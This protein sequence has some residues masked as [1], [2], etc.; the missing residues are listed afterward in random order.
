MRTIAYPGS[1]ERLVHLYG[2]PRCSG[3]GAS[4]VRLCPVCRRRL[5]DEDYLVGRLLPGQGRVKVWG[6]SQCRP[7]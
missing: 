1:E 5:D 4:E 2:C 7:R 3:P 6:C